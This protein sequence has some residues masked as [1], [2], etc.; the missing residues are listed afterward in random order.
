MRR[1][2]AHRHKH[3]RVIELTQGFVAIIDAEDFRKVNRYSWR[4]HRSA[5][6]K[7]KPGKP[8]A[9]ACI[10]GKQ[11]YLHRFVMEAEPEV[12]VDH[13]NHQTLDC[14]KSNLKKCTAKENN[15]ARRCVVRKGR[16]SC[17]KTEQNL[18]ACG[19]A[20]ESA[21]SQCKASSA[22]TSDT[23]AGPVVEQP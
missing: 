12:Q 21:Q 18:R 22:E 4:V 15:H 9:R 16:T 19:S 6:T 8:Y 14:R 7:K 13:R 10:K 23:P 3:F 1:A 17:L 2:R 20:A 11:V 5:G